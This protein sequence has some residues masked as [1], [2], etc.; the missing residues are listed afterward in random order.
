MGRTYQSVTI[1]AP[2]DKVWQRIRDFHDLSWGAGVIEKLDVV[3]ALKGDQI[4][5]KRV[6]NGTFHETLRGLSDLDHTIR[7]TIDD[8]PGTPVAK[9]DVQN[10][11]GEV[12]LFSV[13]EE[14]A[15]FVEW[16]STWD[17]NAAACSEFCH[18]V[19]VALL[20]TLKKSFE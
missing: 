5:A 19:Y 20:G 3:G 12:R 10:Y 15:T 1:K 9:T 16:S 8:A 14:N 2:V 4:G 6:L 7:Y 18:G 13:T 17:N 11:V